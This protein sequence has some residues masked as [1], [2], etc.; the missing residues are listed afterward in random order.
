M[1]NEDIPHGTEY[2]LIKDTRGIEFTIYRYRPEGSEPLA[3]I[4]MTNKK[5]KEFAESILGM[6]EAT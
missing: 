3:L 5:A 6:C 4:R 2:A 1:M